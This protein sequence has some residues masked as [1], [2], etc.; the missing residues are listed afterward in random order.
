L[1]RVDVGSWFN[2]RH[3]HSAREEFTRATVPTLSEVFGLAGTN[4]S[5]LYVELKCGPRE[6]PP[7]VSR[8]VGLIREHNLARR[9]VVESFTLEAVRQVKLI[10][11]ELRT[12]AL[13]EPTLRRPRPSARWMLE[14]AAEHLADEIAPHYSLA[15][16][17][18]A[19]EAA[20]QDKE[21]VVWTVDRPSWI[22]RARSLGIKALITNR[23]DFMLSR[24]DALTER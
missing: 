23:P 6:I 22:E 2:L 21:V 4:D 9:V 16:R 8:V 14:M 10:A 19:T 12:A 11:P 1:G 3:P 5:L 17:R 20:R 18:L 13:F 24:R 7:L 15:S